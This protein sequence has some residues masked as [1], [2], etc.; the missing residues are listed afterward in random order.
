MNILKTLKGWA[1]LAFMGAG[2]WKGFSWPVVAGSVA[3]FLLHH[4][5]EVVA[6]VRQAKTSI[7]A[8]DTGALAR[9]L[10]DLRDK[11]NVLT[12]AAM[13]RPATKDAAP[14]A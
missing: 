8:G 4:W 10:S 5:P 11:V 3:M 6:A 7:D 13:R 1:A 12:I 2:F 14:G 9:E